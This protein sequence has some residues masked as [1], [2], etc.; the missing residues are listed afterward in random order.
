MS[1]TKGLEEVP[2]HRANWVL[3]VNGKATPRDTVWSVQCQY[4]SIQ[5]RVVMKPDGSAGFDRPEYREAPNVNVVP[6][7]I[8]DEGNCLVGVI[9]QA[10]PHLDDPNNRD[11]NDHPPIIVGQVPMG[12]EETI[13]GKLEKPGEAAVREV[14]EE[15][16]SSDTAV[17]KVITPSHPYHTPCPS[18]VPTWSDVC[19]VQVDL[20]RLGELKGE[21]QEA[22]YGAEYITTAE[23]FARLRSGV[24]GE[25]AFYRGCTSN[26]AWL[27]FFAR[28]PEY[29]P[30]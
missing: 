12:F 2:A 19:F 5:N 17:I 10:R 21:R 16:G 15:M 20:K 30:K 23:L 27:M 24:D 7:G 8:D 14:G 13:F 22:I 18:F 6:F 9:R 4:G 28:F 11:T 25:G 1:A 26:S 29:L 3:A